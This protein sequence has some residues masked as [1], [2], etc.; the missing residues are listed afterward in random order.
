MT[1]RLSCV[2]VRCFSTCGECL[3]QVAAAKAPQI[4]APRRRKAVN[5]NESKLHRKY[6]SASESEHTAAK[7]ESGVSSSEDEDRAD[8]K[9]HC[10]AGVFLMLC[11]DRDVQGQHFPVDCTSLCQGHKFYSMHCGT[12][13]L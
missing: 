11:I 3:L 9:V 12:S 10:C 8:T 1:P 2:Y 7:A 4:L 13:K 6:A 5:Y